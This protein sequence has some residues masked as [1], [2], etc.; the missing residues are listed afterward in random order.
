MVFIGQPFFVSSHTHTTSHESRSPSTLLGSSSYTSDPT[1]DKTEDSR[2]ESPRRSLAPR[3]RHALVL[4]LVFITSSDASTSAASP[5]S[6]HLSFVLD[7][8]PARPRHALTFSRILCLQRPYRISPQTCCETTYAHVHMRR[9]RP[10]RSQCRGRGRDR[11]ARGLVQ[12]ARCL[13]TVRARLRRC[14][15]ARPLVEGVLRRLEGEQPR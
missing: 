5:L 14:L 9:R 7:C 3:P 12:G 10:L 8:R 15:G 2:V 13:R 4:S 6:Q 11:S 1:N